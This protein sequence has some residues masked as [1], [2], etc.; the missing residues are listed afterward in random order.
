MEKKHDHTNKLL[1]SGTLLNNKSEKHE[2]RT[3]I[4]L[5]HYWG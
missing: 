3:I 5:Q 1:G 4:L 2:I